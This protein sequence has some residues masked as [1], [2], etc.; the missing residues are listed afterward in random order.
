MTQKR[1]TNKLYICKAW[2][3]RGGKS[4]VRQL[5]IHTQEEE[6]KISKISH[7]SDSKKS[8]I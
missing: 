4:D 5:L 8:G 2:A 3:I 6:G 7:L 1:I